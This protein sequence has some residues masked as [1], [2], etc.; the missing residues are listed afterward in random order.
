MSDRFDT[1]WDPIIKPLFQTPEI[2][3]LSDF[4]IQ[5][6]SLYQVFPEKDLVFNAFRLTSFPKLK[7]VILGQDPYHNDGQAH[8][9]SFSVPQGIAI[10]PSL[11]NIYTEL[12]TD[13]PGFRYPTHGD[14]TK[15]AEQGVLL[16]N[17]TLTVRAHEAGSHQKKGWEYFTDEVIKSISDQSEHVVFMLWGSYAIKKSGLIDHSKHLILT[18]VHPSPLSVYRGFFGS[19]HFSQANSYLSAHGKSAIDWQV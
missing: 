9:L 3:K 13:I 2:Q 5:E 6:R 12:V 17:A 8:G 15:W 10:P 4:V 18:A 11:R 1:S 19:A 16:L 7:V 14:L